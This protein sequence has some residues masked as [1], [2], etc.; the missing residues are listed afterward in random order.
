MGPTTE[1]IAFD[2]GSAN[3]L[4][5]AAVNWLSDGA[6]SFDRDGN[7]A[8]RGTIDQ[9]LLADLLNDP[10][11]DVPAPKSTGKEYFH[12]KYLREHLGTRTVDVDDLLATLC[13]L[14]VETVARAVEAYGVSRAVRRRRWHEKPRPHGRTSSSPSRRCAVA[15]R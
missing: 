15:H 8:A 7:R 3:A 14:T 12:E 5:D 13:E 10:Y 6:E 2:I 4:M 1:P 11:Y 9:A